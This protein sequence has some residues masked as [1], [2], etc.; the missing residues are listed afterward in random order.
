MSYKQ[1]EG[2]GY[3][4]NKYVKENSFI[5]M[6]SEIS[7]LPQ[8]KD[9]KD[10][11]PH[12]FWEGH[13]DVVESYYKA[14]E[15]A[16]SQLKKPT[17]KNG[18][19]SSYI[20]VDFNRCIFMW[21]SVFMLFFGKY[22]DKIF[23]FQNTL[24]NF[25]AKQHCDGFICREILEENGEDQF[26]RIDPIST[27]PNVFAWSE[28]EYYKLFGDKER[29][30]KVFPVLLA[31]HQWLREFRTWPDGGY[32]SS[33]WG[34]G[35]DNIPRLEDEYHVLFSHGHMTWVDITAQQLFNIQMLENIAEVCERTEDIVDLADE[36]NKLLDILNNKLWDEK[37][38]FYYDM[39]KDGSL[40]MKKSVAPYWTLL[41]GAVPANKA[42]AFVAHLD[43]EKEF[44]THHR[45]PSLSADESEYNP[46]GEYWRGSVWSSTN[47]MILKGLSKYGYDKLAYEIARNHV[48]NVTDV[49]KKTD[50]FWENYAPDF[51]EQGNESRPNFVGWTGASA[52]AIFIEHVLGIT[53][54]CDSKI[55]WRV[56]SLS[57][58]GIE[59]YPVGN[60]GLV[61]LE[62]K[63]RKNSLDEPDV[64]VSG[65]CNIEVEIIWDGGRKTITC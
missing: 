59:N 47:Y 51:S 13:D 36:K 11:L 49:F 37:T 20:D 60:K 62:C 3:S 46:L 12:P 10:E 9:I 61:N 55:T 16:F 31:Y 54:D 24:N 30:K 32:W 63:S 64:S 5:N 53:A 19:V 18:F 35:M 45:V 2:F 8:Y 29:L 4:E 23:K 21:D 22:T 41:A 44:K 48:Q 17:E 25:Y 50:T 58:H 26:F 38:S 28:W 14:W 40:N 7:E 33:G 27:G 57:A 39:W 43:N 6:K 15:I 1:N 42:D 56:N 52:I 34:C 65:N